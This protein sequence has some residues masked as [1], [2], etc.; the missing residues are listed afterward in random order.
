MRSWR[1]ITLY[2]YQQMELNTKR[3]DIDELDKS[4]FNLC[5]SY[6]KTESQLDKLNIR[7]VKRMSDRLNKVMKSPVISAAKESIG[8]YNICYNLDDTR[9]GQY[10]ELN[11]FFSSSDL[12][13][14]NAHYIL[15]SISHEPGRKNK[16]ED[17]GQKAAFFLQVPIS[18]VIG[19][20]NKFSEAFLQYNKQWGVLL[21]KPQPQEEEGI[22][23]E[24]P[25]PFNKRFG[26]IFS[27]TQ[28]AEH[29]RI[30]L[31]QAFDLPTPQA[32]NDMVYMKAHAEY[33]KETFKK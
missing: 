20:I 7:K 25:H 23:P 8:H 4:L 2:Q 27:A 26:W 21:D 31:D 15:A 24:A 10:V 1:D 28:V 32:L 9:F 19:T 17:H 16:S 11:T 22:I 12:V 33:L 13:Y 30:S 5:I 3:I 18:D 14:Q 6:D 29:E